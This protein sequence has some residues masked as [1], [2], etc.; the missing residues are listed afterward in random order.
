MTWRSSR[1]VEKHWSHHNAGPSNCEL[2]NLSDQGS[3]D[4]GHRS[5]KLKNKMASSS[6]L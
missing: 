2:E 5:S 6:I 3:V 1:A 4:V